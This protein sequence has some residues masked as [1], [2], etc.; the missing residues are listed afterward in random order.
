M[1]R[2]I[3]GQFSDG[4]ATMMDFVQGIQAAHQAEKKW[5]KLPVEKRQAALLSAVESLIEAELLEADL[6]VSS[7]SKEFVLKSLEPRL[8]EQLSALLSQP[9]PLAQPLGL[10]VLIGN[11]VEPLYSWL[12]PAV[13]ALL[14]GN[15]VILRPSSRAYQSALVF[16]KAAVDAGLDAGL[17]Q[18][19]VESGYEVAEMM[20]AH[21][22][23][24]ATLA[25]GRSETMLS[26]YRR[27]NPDR[28]R[29]YW[30]GGQSTAVVVTKDADLEAAA[31]AVL[32]NIVGYGGQVGSKVSRILVSQV[33]QKDFLDLVVQATKQAQLAEVQYSYDD[34]DRVLSDVTANEGRI[35]YGQPTGAQGGV[36]PVVVRD[37]AYCAGLM[38]QEFV[39]PILSVTDFKYNHEAIS[40]VNNSPFG[41]RAAWFAADVEKAQKITAGLEV[42]QVGFNQI[43][44]AV[45][46]IV[47]EKQSGYG[48][49][50]TG[51]WFTAFSHA[52]VLSK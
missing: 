51:D 33:C 9:K 39:G 45:S 43:P 44:A 36:C 31:D 5:A 41:A 17:F 1:Q 49:R 13:G 10:T 21:P 38:Q 12:L 46:P 52:P 47:G 30:C 15:P 4:P 29:N 32:E 34:F 23:V 3:A 6:R 14:A 16:A 40:W 27:A 2:F 24:K 7:L 28:R 18:V 8:K 26:L 20:L 35:V 48:H 19:L 25:S 11:A 37:L 42:G 50:L 22:G